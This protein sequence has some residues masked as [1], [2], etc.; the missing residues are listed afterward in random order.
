MAQSWT[1]SSNDN[2]QFSSTVT[3]CS[4]NI[5]PNDICFGDKL[6][7][8]PSASNSSKL[9]FCATEDIYDTD[10]N[11]V[12]AK[13][14][15]TDL[16]ILIGKQL[17]I[18]DFYRIELYTEKG[19]EFSRL[20]IILS[21]DIATVFIKSSNP[22]DY[23]RSWIESSPDHTN[24]TT[25]SITVIDQT[26]KYIYDGN[27]SQIK[28]RGNSTW[29]EAKKPYQ[30]K[31]DK[32]ADLIETGDK[33]NKAKTWV[34]LA[35]A[36]DKSSS[37]NETA[38]TLAK[39]LGVSSALDF[40]RVDLYYDGEYRGTYL[41]C[42]K[43]QINQGRIDIRDLE[44]ANGDLNKNIDKS[45]IVEGKN[46]YGFEIRYGEGLVS[47]KDI[48]GGYLIEHEVDASRFMAESSFFTVETTNGV[49]HFV[50][51]SPEIWSYSE[52]N[53][54]S[55]LIQDL[56]DSFANN[57]V[58]PS[59]RGSKRAG[60]RT[61]E[62]LDIDSLVRVYWI[63]EILKNRDGYTF[64]SGYLYKDSDA[65]TNGKITF[66]PVWDFDLTTGNK[67]F[68]ESGNSVIDT[69]GWYTRALGLGRTFLDNSYL[70]NA[71][72]ASRQK[73]IS[74]VRAYLNGGDFDS[75]MK[76]GDASRKMN[77]LIWGQSYESH[78]DVR[79]WINERLNWIERN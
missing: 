22:K 65:S 61:E 73:M 24:A 26:G 3:I 31:L 28:G 39:L 69:N 33:K 79:N 74:K 76:S 49:Q 6:Y 63:N 43:V 51:K 50:C 56:F 54:L 34:L 38:Y 58:V 77:S 78:D 1:F 19:K 48:T 8:L 25:G 67:E 23:G 37:R 47:P 41:L 40:R 59:F 45:R 2:I 13:N 46:E 44:E 12:A 55:C 21:E 72:D 5:S 75:Q 53:Y 60:M 17:P 16:G 15:T 71:I 70:K 30:I 7:L 36:F 18:N 42:E 62:L 64:S 57:G 66:G 20:F 52:A 27:L 29:G 14:T 10:N 9:D 68:L 35:D 4:N 11:L 32:K